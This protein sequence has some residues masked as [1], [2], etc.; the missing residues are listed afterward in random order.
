MT[1]N[2]FMGDL[3]IELTFGAMGAV[4]GRQNFLPLYSQ[5]NC[6][7]GLGQLRE[8]QLVQCDNGEYYPG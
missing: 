3:K 2:W 8:H 1:L 5:I 7:K 6:M 4:A